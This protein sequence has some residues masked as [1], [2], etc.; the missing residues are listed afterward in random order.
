ME[1]ELPALDL[2]VCKESYKNQSRLVS[3]TQFNDG[4]LCAGDLSGEKDTCQGNITI[5]D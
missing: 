4:V 5:M 1:V 3:E 2:S